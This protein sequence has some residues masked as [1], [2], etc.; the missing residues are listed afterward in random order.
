[1]NIIVEEMIDE[2]IQ[3]IKLRN[4]Q[5]DMLKGF[6]DNQF[7]SL[8]ACRQ[9]GKCPLFPTKIKILLNN[10]ELETTIGRFYF[11]TLKSKR[12]L[13]I[14]ENIKYFLWKLY[15]KIDIQ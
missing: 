3:H 13:T 1:M 11:E 4:Y 2:G 7:V 5:Y 12:K 14:L 6:T 8:L 10:E 15:E 9:I